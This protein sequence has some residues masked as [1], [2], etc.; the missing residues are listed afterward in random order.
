ML[1]HRGAHQLQQL[2]L[3]RRRPVDGRAF[4]PRIAGDARDFLEDDL[5][6]EFDEKRDD[7]VRR[8]RPRIET[9]LLA[10]NLGHR[11]LDRGGDLVRVRIVGGQRLADRLRRNVERL[12]CEAGQIGT[13]GG[14]AAAA[15]IQLV[16]KAR[17]SGAGNISGAKPPGADRRAAGGIARI[18]AK[19]FLEGSSR[20][21]RGLAEFGAEPAEPLPF[22]LGKGRSRAGI[23]P[24]RH[25]GRIRSGAFA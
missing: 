8:D 11:L 4:L 17:Q 20:T 14:F 16:E 12:S 24:G 6:E 19:R 23:G 1:V 13:R 10:E 3:A 5:G 21:N 7:L 22:G 9:C 25:E 2:G 18:F 15:G